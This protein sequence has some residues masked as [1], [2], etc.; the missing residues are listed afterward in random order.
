[1]KRVSVCFTVTFALALASGQASAKIISGSI[2]GGTVLGR[3]TFVQL[4]PGAG[5]FTV[6][7]DNF[8]TNNFYA[9]DERQNVVLTQVLAATFGVKNIA[10]GTRINS[11]FVFFDPLATQTLQGNIAFDTP[12]LSAITLR[13]ALIASNY[14]GAAGVT[15]LTPGSVGLEPG[16]DFVALGSPGPDG[17]RV[18]FFSADTPGDHFRVITLADA[19]PEPASWAMMVAGFVGVGNVARKRR[20]IKIVFA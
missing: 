11:H 6:G 5:A 19:V 7:K 1:M 18:N 10:I 17:L 3:G 14:L 2:T 8:N 4:N 9:F 15:Y 13:P 12:V 20:A 16:I